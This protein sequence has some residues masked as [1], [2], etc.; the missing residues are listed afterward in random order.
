M[1]LDYWFGEINWEIWHHGQYRSMNFSCANM[2]LNQEE[3]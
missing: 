1:E 3:K 2:M